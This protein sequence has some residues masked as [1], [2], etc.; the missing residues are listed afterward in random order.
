M[1]W[2]VRFLFPLIR[3]FSG[4][5]LRIGDEVSHPDMGMFAKEDTGFPGL[6]DQPT[7]IRCKHVI[8][9]RV[10]DRVGPAF[11]LTK[12]ERRA[13]CDHADHQGPWHLEQMW[14]FDFSNQKR[15]ENYWDGGC[16]FLRVS[17][18][19]LSLVQAQGLNSRFERTHTR[20]TILVCRTATESLG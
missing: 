7:W 4:V 2:H 19:S 20:S 18:V 11:S 17:T 13:A 6:V 9:S 5:D 1:P 3:T 14:K 15:D 16:I 8:I 12:R 10:I